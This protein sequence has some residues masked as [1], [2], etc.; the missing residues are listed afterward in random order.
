M[1]S[2]VFACLGILLLLP[3]MAEGQE[4][5]LSV[6]GV[7]QSPSCQGG[8]DG[9]IRLQISGGTGGY[10][11]VWNSGQKEK[12]VTQLT[13]GTYMV[14]VK[15]GQGCTGTAE[16]VL[17]AEGNEPALQVQQK[18]AS[19]GKKV[20]DVRFAG[21]VRPQA[22]YIKNLTKGVRAPQVAYTGQALETGTYLLEAFTG[23]GCSTR[24]RVTIEAN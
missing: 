6:K 1:K 7:V 17:S 20:L 12:D 2:L 13:S 14:T 11:Y 15:D 19:A 16:F 10:S 18:A 9:S 23:A 5:R 8:M 4:C 3:F 21:S 22:V 24:Q